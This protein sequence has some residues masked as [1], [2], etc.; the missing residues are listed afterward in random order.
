M[1]GLNVATCRLI[2]WRSKDLD[3]CTKT[4][5][6]HLSAFSKL[7]G[8]K[9]FD[10]KMYQYWVC[11]MAKFQLALMA[12]VEFVRNALVR[13]ALLR[14]M[15]LVVRRFDRQLSSFVA[16][17]KLYFSSLR[18]FISRFL[19]SQQ[20]WVQRSLIFSSVL[21]LFFNYYSP[22][23]QTFLYDFDKSLS[24]SAM[25]L[26]AVVT[27]RFGWPPPPDFAP[28]VW[29]DLGYVRDPS[30]QS[31]LDRLDSSNGLPST[32][33]FDQKAVRFGSDLLTSPHFQRVN[34]KA[35]SSVLK[36]VLD[37]GE[38][39]PASMP[40]AIFVDVDLSQDSEFES[41]LIIDSLQDWETR[42]RG[43][44]LI[45]VKR[46][47][48]LSTEAP[49]SG[50]GQSPATTSA[51]FWLPGPLDAIVDASSTIIFATT[52]ISVDANGNAR[53]APQWTCMHRFSSDK[54]KA[55]VPVPHFSTIG[56]ALGEP[57]SG[58]LS[59]ARQ[60][61]TLI[62]KKLV[63]EAPECHSSAHAK[64]QQVAIDFWL[65]PE[66]IPWQM[67][68][69]LGTSADDGANNV[70]SPKIN[71]K[72]LAR[73]G[74]DKGSAPIS[75][76]S[77][78]R[79]NEPDFSITG[80]G[81]CGSLVILGTNT[82]MNPDEIFS[83]IGPLAGPL[84]HAMA[85]STPLLPSL[86]EYSKLFW[87]IVIVS[88]CLLNSLLLRLSEL[89]FETL[90]EAEKRTLF[91]GIGVL[92]LNPVTIKLISSLFFGIGALLVSAAVYPWLGFGV[93]AVPLYLAALLETCSIIGRHWRR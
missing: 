86:W 23:K 2:P 33:P 1:A 24:Y 32:K 52:E 93:F 5:A 29:V 53:E 51:E 20:M 36:S 65:H 60:A 7:K 49:E 82:P 70:V 42:S 11:A 54:S 66:P 9:L 26:R 79:T 13:N 48:T 21:F 68:G 37:A 56:R 71:Q 61:P 67:T 18:R 35:I 72:W 41:K 64:Q 84:L 12:F 81:L 76:V 59:D 91:N 14:I 46:S 87:W 15:A 90:M 77:I 10:Y 75:A 89:K 38:E 92:V 4:L 74:C 34:R 69:P 39:N 44:L 63:S 3:R 45:L 50:G 62:K 27:S 58:Q 25:K 19:Y 31:E 16:T 43:R 17:F 78:V 40:A 83:P 47:I 57:N 30:V 28:V 55:L 73:S 85:M 80:Y 88:F 22:L 6:D 8:P